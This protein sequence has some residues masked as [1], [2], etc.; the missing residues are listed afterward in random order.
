M[1]LALAQMDIEW[2]QKEANQLRCHEFIKKASEI[3]VQK[4]VFPEL[5]LTGFSM[6]TNKISEKVKKINHKELSYD[7]PTINFFAGMSKEYNIAIAFGM[8]KEHGDKSSNEFYMTDCKGKIIMEYSK[9]HP[10]SFGEESNHYI[11][12]DKLSYCTLGG[13][14]LSA[15]ICYDL[16]FPEI[17]QIA[18]K[19][20]DG[21]IV[22]ANWPSERKDHWI[23]LLKARA[24]ENQCYIIGVNRV[25][26]GNGLSYQGD[27]MIIDPYG[28]CISEKYYDIK[29]E[30]PTL[31]ENMDQKTIGSLI[32]GEMDPSVVKQYRGEFRIK[33]DRRQELYQKLYKD[34]K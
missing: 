16:R 18:A 5:S 29:M 8:V 6:N 24:I 1:K 4:I 32:V 14:N 27:S 11:G 10:F 25:G 23:T 26:E 20:S 7:S 22:I 34:F 9:I 31:P 13:L 12:G 33:D 30:N 15:L 2:E 19:L 21:I 28:N 17:F 3:K